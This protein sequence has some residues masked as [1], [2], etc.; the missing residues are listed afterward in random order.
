MHYS[1]SFKEYIER[2]AKKV[3]SIDSEYFEFSSYIE[4]MRT[5]F[6]LLIALIC[7]SNVLCFL[8]IATWFSTKWFGQHYRALIFTLFIPFVTSLLANIIF[9]NLNRAFREYFKI[10]SK[11]CSFLLI[12]AFSSLPIV[13]IWLML[14]WVAMIKRFTSN[15]A[16]AIFDK[17]NGLTSGVFI[18]DFADNVNFEGKLVSFDNTKD[19]NRDFVHFY[20]EAKL[21]RDKITLQTNP[22]PHERM[23]VNRM[24]YQQK[25]SMGANQNSPSTAFANLKRY[26]EHKQQKIIKIKQ[27]ILT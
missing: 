18:F 27:F 23:Y 6:G 13:N 9:I 25:L 1:Y 4:R 16:F 24:Y 10:T 14:W 19:T 17:Y 8:F 12:C 11:S 26:V 15:Y 22:I 5:V 20:S 21:K 2:F 7:F 3:N